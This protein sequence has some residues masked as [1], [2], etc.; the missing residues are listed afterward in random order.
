M[1]FQGVTR[2]FVKDSKLKEMGKISMPNRIFF[3]Y[4]RNTI[5]AHAHN[6]IEITDKKSAHYKQFSYKIY[7]LVMHLKQS[8]NAYQNNLE[9][10]YCSSMDRGMD[11]DKLIR[12]LEEK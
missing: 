1:I 10:E 4:Q 5:P 8:V 6:I 2:T 9:I 3:N 7:M 12:L 11:F